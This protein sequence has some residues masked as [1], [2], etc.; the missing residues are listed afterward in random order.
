VNLKKLRELLDA[1]TTELR[2]LRD[3]EERT[4]EIRTQM[5]TLA[6][7][8][9]E[10]RTNITDEEKVEDELRAVD[11]A[12]KTSAGRASENDS[13]ASTREERRALTVGEQLT[14]SDEYRTWS[15]LRNDNDPR[16]FTFEVSLE[17]R[18]IMGT[19]VLP[20]GYAQE[21]R[22]PGIGRLADPYGS[23]RDV[24]L[25]GSTNAESLRFFQED[26]FTNAAAFVGESTDLTGETG[27]KPQSGITFTTDTATVGTIAHFIPITNQLEW[28]APELRSYIDGRLMDGLQLTEDDMLL[29][30]D[31]T[32][33]DPVGIL[34]TDDIQIL[35]NTYFAGAATTNAGTDIEPFDRI[36]RAR[37]LI[38][39][40][41]RSRPSFIVMHPA[42]DEEFQ[43]LADADGH[44]YGGGPFDSGQPTRFWGLTRILN[45]NMPEGKALVGDGRQAQIW[46]RMS[47]R[48]TVGLINA[49]FIRNQKTLLAE[50]RVGLAV[51]RPAAFALVDLYA[52]A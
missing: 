49:Q 52:G 19:A 37:R 24:L 21:Q 15:A 7:E 48:I 3:G 11:T 17:R 18:A 22:L 26:V 8:I 29:N 2:A 45:E 46:D 16:G 40:V 20:T 30:G 50:K 25:V 23:L 44:Y 27:Q 33:E 35:D 6:D 10:I 9:T 31:G 13:V 36:A 14:E 5:R 1:K 32:G 42:D 39:D 43:T 28:V 51:Y 12:R 41:A 47:A 34:E 4:D 38:I